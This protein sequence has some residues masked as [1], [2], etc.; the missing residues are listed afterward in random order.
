[1]LIKKSTTYKY[2]S[3]IL[4]DC[5]R[6]NL[7]Y[8][9]ILSL[10]SDRLDPTL[11]KHLILDFQYLPTVIT[12]WL[13]MIQIFMCLSG[14]VCIYRLLS[15]SV[16]L[17]LL[18]SKTCKN[19]QNLQ[20]KKFTTKKNYCIIQKKFVD[21]QSRVCIHLP[22][23]INPLRKFNAF[24]RF[25]NIWGNSLL[26]SNCFWFI[27]S[28]LTPYSNLYH[29]NPAVT[30]AIY[31]LLCNWKGMLYQ[32]RRCKVR[33]GSKKQTKMCHFTHVMIKIS[34]FEAEKT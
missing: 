5:I 9:K 13:A 11:P 19:L 2:Y 1:M 31:Q 26:L 16:I 34:T 25:F 20:T 17:R 18:N 14:L 15:R 22:T 30:S 10:N 27:F 12:I 32:E 23:P 21:E 28:P 4:N 29:Q 6:K 33:W 7:L 3:I 24:C 8:A